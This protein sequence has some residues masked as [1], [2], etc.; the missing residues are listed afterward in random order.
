MGALE[1]AVPDQALSDDRNLQPLGRS[2]THAEVDRAKAV[3]APTRE[4]HDIPRCRIT[5]ET[6]P[7]FEQPASHDS[8]RRN[9][10]GFDRCDGRSTHIHS[11]TSLVSSTEPDG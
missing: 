6:S 7:Q 10:G 2:P 9:I 3:D 8:M 11:A 1:M 5:L 4:S